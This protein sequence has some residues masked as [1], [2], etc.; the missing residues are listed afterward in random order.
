MGALAGPAAALSVAGMVGGTYAN[1]KAAKEQRKAAEREAQSIEESSAFDEGQ[2]RYK[3]GLVQGQARAITAASGIDP[4][5][6][7]AILMELENARRTELEALNI[8]RTGKIAAEGRRYE[9]K[10]AMAKIPGAIF[11]GVSGTG[12]ILGQYALAR[13]TPNVYSFGNGGGGGYPT[14]TE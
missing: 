14:G 11:G 1:I 5:S 12:S 6:K 4:G 13:R 8:R 2:Y 7:S 9:G 10:L 3:A